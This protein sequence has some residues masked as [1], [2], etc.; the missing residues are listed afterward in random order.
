[1]DKYSTPNPQQLRRQLRLANL[2]L[3]AV[4]AGAGIASV[5][6]VVAYLR[7]GI[8]PAQMMVVVGLALLAAIPT[9]LDRRHTVAELER[10]N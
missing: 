7:D 10:G 8:F 9:Y 3:T 5:A 1:M 6:S 4:V 2:A